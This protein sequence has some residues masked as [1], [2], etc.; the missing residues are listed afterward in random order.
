VDDKRIT[1]ILENGCLFS[2][3]KDLDQVA[4]KKRN[5]FNLADGGPDYRPG[6]RR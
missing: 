6:N 1:L 2:T 3:V 4:V 5:V